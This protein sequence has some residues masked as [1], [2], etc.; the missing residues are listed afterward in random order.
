MARV[1]GAERPVQQATWPY[2]TPAADRFN[3]IERSIEKDAWRGQR[4]GKGRHTK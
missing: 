4:I 1:A 3:G 2:R